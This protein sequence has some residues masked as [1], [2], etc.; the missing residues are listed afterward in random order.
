M[1]LD[2]IGFLL[3]HAYLAYEGLAAEKYEAIGA[4]ARECGVLA[5]IQE[6]VGG[7]QLELAA[8]LGV[9]RT[10]MAQLLETLEQRGL[11]S[12]VPLSTDRR[13]NVVSLTTDGHELL[14]R[15]RS[16]REEM[17]REFLSPIDPRDRAAFRTALHAIIDNR[18]GSL[19]TR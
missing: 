9:D 16:V 6:V 13:K 1:A 2:R 3:K 14:A 11:V 19:G 10:T 5:Q 18:S 7:S 17:D 4:T 15:D 12:R 8:E